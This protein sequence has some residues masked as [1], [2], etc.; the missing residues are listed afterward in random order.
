MRLFVLAAYLLLAGSCSAGDAKES[1]APSAPAGT[2]PRQEPNEDLLERT[3]KRNPGKEPSVLDVWNEIVREAHEKAGAISSV[4]KPRM[5]PKGAKPEIIINYDGLITFDGKALRLGD[6]IDT[7]RQVLPKDASC[8]FSKGGVL[9]PTICDWELLGISVIGSLDKPAIA[10]QFE[11]YLNL[12]KVEPWMIESG[13]ASGPSKAFPGY[14]ELDGYGIDNHT[15]FRELRAGVDARREL[16]CGIQDC[17]HP[18]G[19]GGGNRTHVTVRVDGR[20]ERDRLRTITV[21]GS[22]LSK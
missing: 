8:K 10:G 14:L 16:D 18:R 2:Q 9:D 3:R 4:G 5:V 22:V 21:V 11:I 6:S 17:S 20:S 19:G 12:E 1:A 13:R 15:T 7:W